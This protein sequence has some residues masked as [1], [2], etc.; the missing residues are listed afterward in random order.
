MK[1]GVYKREG[2]LNDKPTTYTRYALYDFD[3]EKWGEYSSGAYVRR[4]SENPT[5]EEM[6]AKLQLETNGRTVVV[7][8]PQWME[9]QDGE[10]TVNKNPV[11][12]VEEGK[13]KRDEQGGP[14]ITT[15][16]LEYR[17]ENNV[18]VLSE[19]EELS[20]ERKTYLR[21]QGY[22]IVPEEKWEGIDFAEEF[23]FDF[24]TED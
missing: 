24:H 10:V 20:D 13:E 12:T 8:T 14:L 23:S 5:P 4:V 6:K 21:E 18:R 16:E 15:I 3:A 22:D 9:K 17:Q 19:S 1:L 2:L 11:M 7:H